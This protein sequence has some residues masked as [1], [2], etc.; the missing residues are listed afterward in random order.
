LRGASTWCDLGQFK[1]GKSTLLNALVGASPLPTGFAPVTSAVTVVRYDDS[2]GARVQTTDAGWQEIAPGTLTDYATEDRN[3]GNTKRVTGIDVFEPAPLLEKGLCL[4]VLGADPPITGD[5][6]TLIGEVA[7]RVPH[8][9]FVLAKSDRI[10]DV[11][12]QEALVAISDPCVCGCSHSLVCLS[13][14]AGGGVR[15]EPPPLRGPMTPTVGFL[16]P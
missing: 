2:R 8:L 3:P 4:V 11:E 5:E 7:E 9:L 12:R 13:S 14:P 15:L 1:R 6:L 16:A 10:S